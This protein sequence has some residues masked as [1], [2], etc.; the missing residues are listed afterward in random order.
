MSCPSLSQHESS[1]PSNQTY[2]LQR[3]LRRPDHSLILALS[4]L[5]IRQRILAPTSSAPIT[6]RTHWP[7]ILSA[8]FSIWSAGYNDACLG[9]L[10]PALQAHYHIDTAFVALVYLANFAGFLTAAFSNA[11]ATVKVG[12]GG[13]L[14]IGAIAQLLSYAMYAWAPPYPLFVVTFYLAGFGV[15]LQDAQTN[16]WVASLDNANRWLG[17]LHAAYGFGA[18]I[19]PFVATSF[20]VHSYFNYFLSYGA[21]YWH[22]EYLASKL[23]LSGFHYFRSAKDASGR[24]DEFHFVIR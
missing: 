8:Y 18:F 12:V 17:Y 7:K 4:R 9:A 15:A 1:S 11:A 21:R 22:S 20:V 23:H 10:I 5:M 16:A 14:V 19:A 3:Q 24:V 2:L 13:V 6:A